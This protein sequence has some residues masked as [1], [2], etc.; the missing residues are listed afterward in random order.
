MT[1][2]LFINEQNAIDF[3]L[4]LEKLVKLVIDTGSEEKY[5]RRTKKIQTL[6]WKNYFVFLF[7]SYFC[8]KTRAS[9]LSFTKVQRT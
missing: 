4:K 2:S 8:G 7:S 6:V 5:Q 9:L 1:S 3:F